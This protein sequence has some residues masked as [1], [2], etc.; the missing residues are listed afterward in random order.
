M[1]HFASLVQLSEGATLSEGHYVGGWEEP[2]YKCWG[3]DKVLLERGLSP[4]FNFTASI[5]QVADSRQHIVGLCFKIV[6]SNL[7]CSV[8][9]PNKLFKLTVKNS[10]N[11]KLWKC[12]TMLVVCLRVDGLNTERQDSRGSQL[13]GDCQQQLRSSGRLVQIQFY[14]SFDSSQPFQNF[15]FSEVFSGFCS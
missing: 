14:F 6:I 10:E 1:L 7:S 5:W 12:V 8:L 9:R 13:P 2:L 15:N 4:S 11:I 3:L